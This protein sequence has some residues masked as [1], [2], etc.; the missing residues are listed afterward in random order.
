MSCQYW[1]KDKWVSEEQF[2]EML[3]NGLLDHYIHEG[4]FKLEGFKLKPKRKEKVAARTTIP[5]SKLAELLTEEV[6]TRQGYPENILAALEL[7]PDGSDFKIPLWASNYADKFESL[8]TAIINNKIVKQ[9]FSG[10]SYVLGSEEGFE[11]K[12]GEEAM[13]ELKNSKI[14]FS[15]SFNPELGL[16]P[17]RFDEKTGELLPGQIMIPFNFKNKDKKGNKLKL[18]DYTKMVDGRMM[19][20]MDKIP[21][22]M[23]RLFGF[24]IPSQAHNS[25][26][27]L[28]IVGFLPE[29]MGDLMLAPKDFTVQ[30]GSD[31]DV[32]KL[33][34]YM[35]NVKLQKDGKLSTDFDSEKELI[36]N[37]QNTILDIHHAVLSN[38][39]EDMVRAILAPDS[40]GEFEDLA[41]EVYDLKVKSGQIKD[42]PTLLSDDYQKNKYINATAGKDGVGNFSLDSTFNSIIQGKELVYFINDDPTIPIP[43]NYKDRIMKNNFSVLFGDI[44]SRG[45]L[46]NP[47][48]LNSQKIIEKAG[49]IDKL[50][51]EQKRALKFKSKVIQG[52]QSSAVDNEKAQILDKLNI[53]NDTFDTIRAMSLLGFEENEI[54]GLITQDIIVEYVKAMKSNNSSLTSYNPNALKDFKDNFIKKYDPTGKINDIIVNKEDTIDKY[55]NKSTGTEL[56]NKLK[57]S[58]L[59][60]GKEASDKVIEQYFLLEKFLQL[61][62]VGKTIKSVQSSINTESSGLPK[63]LIETKTKVDQINQLETSSI[64]NAETL[65]GEYENGK[66]VLPNTING[67]AAFH[68][69]IFGYSIYE[70]FF[71]YSNNGLQ[72]QLT[73]ILNHIPNG[74]TFSLSKLT[75]FKM[76]VMDEIRS[77]LFSDPSIGIHSGNSFSEQVRLFIDSENNDSLATI[78]EKI[79]KKN[80]AW[81]IKNQF[82]NKLSTSL[83][84]N[85]SASRINFEASTGE[86]LDEKDI[87]LG[88]LNLLNTERDL[89][90]FNGIQYSSRTFAQDLISYAYLEGGQQGAKQFLKYIPVEYLKALGFGEYLSKVDFS[91]TQ[92]FKGA[93]NDIGEPIYDLPSRFTRQFFQNNP[94]K[95]RKIST[96]ETIVSKDEREMEIKKDSISNYLANDETLTKF[97]AVYDAKAPGKHRLYEYDSYSRKYLRI[98]T[99]KND[100]GFKQYDVH[101]DINVPSQKIGYAV[102]PG[103][104]KSQSVPTKVE[105]NAKQVQNTNPIIKLSGLKLNNSLKNKEAIVDLLN[106]IS[107]SSTNSYYKKL[108][109]LYADLN[110]PENFK[111]NLDS[112]ENPRVK[113]SFNSGSNTL[114]LYKNL[115]K[116]DESINDLAEAVLHELTHLFTSSVVKDFNVNPNSV[117]TK[118]KTI[119]NKIKGLQA[120]Y[121]K[122]LSK[123]ELSELYTFRKSYWDMKLKNNQVSKEEYDNILSEPINGVD[124]L[125]NNEGEIKK[126]FTNKYYGSIKLEEF[127][128]MA[129]TNAD[130]QRYLNKITDSDSKSLLGKFLSEIAELIGSLI[131]INVEK[132]SLLESSLIEINNLIK[133]NQAQEIEDNSVEN[134]KYQLFPGVYANSG[135]TKA[136]DKMSEFLKNDDDQFLLKGRGG[137]GK[138][139]IIKK[140]IDNSGILHNRIIGATVADEARGILASNLPSTITTKTM[141]GLLGLV[142]DYSKQGDL[143]FR[144][145]NTREQMEFDSKG[146]SDPIEN[147]KLII[148]DEAS[149]VSKDLY[150]ILMRKK[151]KDAK[152]IFMGDNA[153]IPPINEDGKSTDSPVF[154]LLEKGTNFS[155]LTERMRQGEESPILPVTD[156][157]AENIENIQRG[158]VGKAN[159]LK[160][161]TDVFD[162][163]SNSGV[164]FISD[165]QTLIDSFIE[166]FRQNNDTKNAII[167]GAR[168]EI[169][170]NFSKLIR[171]KLF[172]ATD[173]F[174]VGDVIRVNSPHIVNNQVEFANGFKGKVTQVSPLG[175]NQLGIQLYN[176]TVEY[177]SLDSAG[178]PIRSIANLTTVSPENK[179]DVKKALKNLAAKAKAKLI[180]WKVFYTLKESIVDVGYNYAITAHKVQGSTY[181]NVYVL[182]EDIMSF[183]GGKLQ[184]NR[185]MYTAVSRPSTKLVIFSNKNKV[186][187][188]NAEFNPDYFS[189]QTPPMREDGDPGFDPTFDP[190]NF[191]KFGGNNDFDN[192]RFDPSTMYDLPSL[193][194]FDNLKRICK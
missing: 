40:F 65:L 22:K 166:D 28:E 55:K 137:T 70:K 106:K 157:F 56:I 140:I 125:F 45:D 24:R 71:P 126:G 54:V 107:E 34:T 19:I 112:S 164:E 183:P 146:K 21:E 102:A 193:E 189:N 51:K 39:N 36:E 104:Q 37:R 122:S 151:L 20:D 66:L 190:E 153:Q 145:R 185:M 92:L 120:K 41:K 156:V 118:Q 123:A 9:K 48:T 136:L 192:D 191:S 96:N 113:A 87:Y 130:F 31:F 173:P 134:T 17:I 187:A 80:E 179:L 138:T 7:T 2:K 23:L 167:I 132:G 4:K 172:D 35:Y 61:A 163:A 186:Q 141:V 184:Q 180:P 117:T 38:S 47:Y 27:S 188:E 99:I 159:P 144:E 98:P 25:M 86:N 77:Y 100:Y 6:K 110:Y 59:V 12:E 124:D 67:F 148:I 63:N 76:D 88:F 111:F 29:E 64:L 154:S 158:E 181:K 194:E 91:F 62:D 152:V 82:L 93:V 178:N 90:K 57:D 75:E 81:F 60:E 44:E 171:Q 105:T 177:D 33:Y 68:G 32:D 127:I 11:L 142:P 139:T 52:L 30:M 131:G 108:A 182:E 16:L 116:E 13:E 84:T 83:Q 73:D 14:V 103:F 15:D 143:Y 161:R 150:D 128:T 95:V 53:N 109:E 97:L 1:V 169:V 119:L 174:V 129:L 170:D 5:A 155:E 121:T 89:G 176:I 114:T 175:A 46:S 165:K 72:T 3:Q 147:A 69:A 26:A 160:N 43:N 49:G 85:G 115:Y 135:Q 79:K 8:L 168:N 42:T 18:S 78:F 149:M 10:H 162:T 133:E 58:Q 74:S 94:D 101:N 50:S